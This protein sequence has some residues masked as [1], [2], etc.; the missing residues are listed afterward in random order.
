MYK[1]YTIPGSCSTGIHVL[2]N[3]LNV[4]VEIIKRE[5]VDDY[6]ALVPTNQVPALASDELLLTEGA[7]IVLHLFEQHQVDFELLGGK[8]AF[9]QWLMFN[10]STLHPAYSKLFTL[11]GIMEEGDEKQNVMQKL[12]DKVAQSWEIVEQRLDKQKYITGD[13]VSVLDYLLAIYVGW[14]NAFPTLKISL[15]ENVRKLVTEVS[16]HSEFATAFA[17]EGASFKVPVNS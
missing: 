13:N 14:G 16:Q 15:G 4:P 1:L 12:A 8:T 9:K 3:Q 10:Y 2:L 17:K 11:N 6:S 7:A 5:D